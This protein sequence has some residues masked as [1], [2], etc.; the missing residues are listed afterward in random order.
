MNGVS[1]AMEDHQCAS[2]L[3]NSAQRGFL[4]MAERLVLQHFELVGQRL[5]QREL[6]IDHEID[7]RIDEVV[8]AEGAQSRA[9]HLQPV[10][11]RLED[12]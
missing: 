11:H 12:V 9:R 6:A 10:A 4:G 1:D 8:D 7:Q 2:C 3:M 5:D